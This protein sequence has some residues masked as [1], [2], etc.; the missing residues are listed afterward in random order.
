MHHAGA[1][2]E[3]PQ[4]GGGSLYGR[5]VAIQPQETSAGGGLF[6]DRL[7]VPAAADGAVQVIASR[8][9]S[10]AGEH[11]REQHRFVPRA[12]FAGRL[13]QS[14]ISRNPETML[15][16]VAQTNIHPAMM[17]ASF[18]FFAE[19]N[20]FFREIPPDQRYLDYQ[21]AFQRG[22]AA[23][24]PPDAKAAWTSAAKALA[25]SSTWPS[26][27]PSGALPETAARTLPPT[28]A[29]SLP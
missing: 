6:E 15:S 21:R 7:C 16:L 9:G 17:E 1:R 29:R 10:K 12:A 20:P 3:A 25:F 8:G 2:T 4:A 19:D 18:V 24:T 13:G 14:P 26:R 11:F 23:T 22:L 28:T 27:A 5:R